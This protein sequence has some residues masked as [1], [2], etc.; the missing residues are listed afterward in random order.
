VREALDAFEAAS[1]SNPARDRRHT[2]AHIQVIHPGDLARFAALGV[3]AN[4]QPYWAVSERQMDVLTIP[5][6][7]PERTGWQYPFGTLLHVGARLAFG[8]DWAVSTPNPLEEIEVAVRRVSPD[9]R[10][11]TPFL[12]HERITLEAAVEA[13]TLG[14]A[15]VNGLDEETGSIEVGKLADLAVLDRDL[16]APGT[17]PADARVL[18]TLVEGA[19]VFED[20]GLEG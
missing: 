15:Y 6:L 16:F 10:A 11:A 2:I 5:F 1:A 3:V 20:P 19:P 7:G 8:S 4:G 18:L 13:F 9:H 17:L 14:A 12:P